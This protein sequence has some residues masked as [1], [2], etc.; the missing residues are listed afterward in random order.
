MVQIQRYI[1]IKKEIAKG[2]SGPRQWPS[3]F[4]K[5]CEW[6]LKLNKIRK[7]KK[8]R[9]AGRPV[10]FF[11]FPIRTFRCV[12]FVAMKNVV[13]NLFICYR[14]QR[15]QQPPPRHQT[16]SRNAF[17]PNPMKIVFGKAHRALYRPLADAVCPH[18]TAA[19]RPRF[20]S[21]FPRC[22][23]FILRAQWERKPS[24]HVKFSTNNFKTNGS[25]RRTNLF[26]QM[27]EESPDR[28]SRTDDSTFYR[29][30]FPNKKKTCFVK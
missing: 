20:A 25:F 29:N 23:S 26:G 24:V 4:Q 2:R 27:R 18:S 22:R 5:W 13:R 12:L 8:S 17:R 28:T 11:S 21:R 30:I 10:L 9:I 1:I 16:K 14:A 19:H 3:M 15:N 7:K 6:H